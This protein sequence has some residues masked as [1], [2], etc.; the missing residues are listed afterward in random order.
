MKKYII[1]IGCALCAQIVYAS[2]YNWELDYRLR[3]IEDS[4]RRIERQLKQEREDRWF[5]ETFKL[6]R[7]L[8][9]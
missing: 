5:Y 9:K 8:H 3:E 4:N 1:T 6:V 7:S 2:D